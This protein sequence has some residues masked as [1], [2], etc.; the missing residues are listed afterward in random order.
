MTL[1]DNYLLWYLQ[2]WDWSHVLLS[3]VPQI[4]PTK[5]FGI[6]VIPFLVIVE[7]SSQGCHVSDQVQLLGTAGDQSRH[8]A[9]Q[10]A[11]G[12]LRWWSSRPGQH[13]RWVCQRWED[14][15]LVHSQ[16]STGETT[17]QYTGF[18]VCEKTQVP[19]TKDTSFNDCHNFI[20]KSFT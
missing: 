3:V 13:H 2:R 1:K 18:K 4:C 11:V 7:Y 16:I 20:F 15:C 5:C 8:H 9:E 14:C 19:G 6:F 17:I 12:L 10:W